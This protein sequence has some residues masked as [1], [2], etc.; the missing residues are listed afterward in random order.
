M[1]DPFNSPVLLKEIFVDAICGAGINNEASGKHMQLK[2]LADYHIEGKGDGWWYWKRD[3]L[4]KLPTSVLVEIY[5]A[6]K[7]KSEWG[8]KNPI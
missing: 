3:G 8:K 2:G 7:R 1:T 4:N 6:T 5:V